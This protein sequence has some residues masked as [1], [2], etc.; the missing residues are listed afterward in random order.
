MVNKLWRAQTITFRM[1]AYG[2]LIGATIVRRRLSLIAYNCK[3]EGK[4]PTVGGQAEFT[5]NITLR[6]HPSSNVTYPAAITCEL[7]NSQ[8]SLA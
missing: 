8:S 6:C 3:P 5:E 7:V 2:P 1:D 4:A